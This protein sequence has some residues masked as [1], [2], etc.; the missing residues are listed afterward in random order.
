[1]T[2]DLDNPAHVAAYNDGYMIGLSDGTDDA[3]EQLD[4]R[5]DEIAQLKAKLETATEDA[6]RSYGAM[7]TDDNARLAEENTRLTDEL[8]DLRASPAITTTDHIRTACMCFGVG[9]LVLIAAAVLRL[10][11]P[12]I[13]PSQLPGMCD[14]NQRGN[15]SYA[16][17]TACEILA[18]EYDNWAALNEDYG[19]RDASGR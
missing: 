16:A 2:Y 11:W 18:Q 12:V 14:W 17:A 6:V 7:L 8:N 19:P 1:M 15:L 3:A 4:L 5:A 13:P 10:A 9:A